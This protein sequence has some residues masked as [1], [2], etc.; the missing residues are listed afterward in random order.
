MKNR[1]LKVLLPALLLVSC[2]KEKKP[3]LDYVDILIGT[4][5]ANTLS[6][7]SRG[8]DHV[9]YGQTIPAVTAPFGMT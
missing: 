9:D 1:L 6:A 4:A 7:Q 3:L 5:P 2:E 8:G